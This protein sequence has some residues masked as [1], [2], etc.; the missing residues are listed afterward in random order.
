MAL[1][2]AVIW[3]DTTIQ[4]E[5]SSPCF[6]RLKVGERKSRTSIFKTVLK[7]PVKFIFETKSPLEEENRKG[8]ANHRNKHK[9]EGWASILA[10]FS[11][12][13]IVN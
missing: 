10:L 5:T 4:K 8:G 11:L 1:W 7:L 9:A 6:W 3:E 2:G 13:I 12:A